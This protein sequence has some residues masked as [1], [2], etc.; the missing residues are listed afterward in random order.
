MRLTVDAGLWMLGEHGLGPGRELRYD[1]P[2]L[3]LAVSPAGNLVAAGCQDETI[4]LWEVGNADAD[5]SGGGYAEKV[6]IVVWSPC[7]NYLASA[8]GTHTIVWKCTDEAAPKGD[9]RGVRNDAPT[10]LCIRF[11]PLVS[12]QGMMCWR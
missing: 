8:G 7:G 1:G 6:Q 10:R 2:L 4:H 12:E 9:S 5:F 3:S 11:A